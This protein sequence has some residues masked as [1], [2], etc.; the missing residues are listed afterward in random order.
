MCHMSCVTCHVS[1]VMCHVSCVMCHVSCVMCHVLN[2]L[3]M[4]RVFVSRKERNQ[5]I[6]TAC[7]NM[8]VPEMV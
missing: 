3:K 6:L 8:P 1:C 4:F 7:I 5:P 2:L